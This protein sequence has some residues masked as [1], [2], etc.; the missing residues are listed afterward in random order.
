MAAFLSGHQNAVLAGLPVNDPTLSGQVNIPGCH[1]FRA[2][3]FQADPEMELPGEQP[4]LDFPIPGMS[5]LMPY[6]STRWSRM[7]DSML[8]DWEA[9]FQIAL[10]NIFRE[11]NPQVV[12]S[13]HLWL[14]TALARRILPDDIPVIGV[15]H[16]TCLRQMTLAPGV[17]ARA[18]PWIAR[19]NGIGLLTAEQGPC[20]SD[21]LI[22][23]G[24]GLPHTEVVGSGYSPEIF[25]WP[26]RGARSNTFAYAGKL[27]CSKGLHPLL[28][29]FEEL[30]NKACSENWE[31][32][33]TLVLAGGGQGA[34]ADEIRG[35]AA[36]IPGVTL[37]GRVSQ[38]QLAE[39]FG[40]SGTMVLPSFYEGLPLVIAEALA[41]GARVICSDLPGLAGWLGKELLAAGHVELVKLPE[42]CGIDTPIPE[43]LPEFQRRLLLAMERLAKETD[44]MDMASETGHF[45]A[46]QTWEALVGRILELAIQ[47]PRPSQ[48]VPSNEDS[49]LR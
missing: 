16:G 42:M 26:G 22:N 36:E 3:T 9:C 10:E 8:A 25:H 21:H 14:L 27:A 39:L 18:L 7:E 49:F 48:P 24:C 32:L 40:R 11:F 4:D 46:A 38:S 29:A 20:L 44:E 43:R 5:D 23:L 19:L 33:P 31:I 35:R 1:L 47:P 2:V 6:P 45:L 41:C 17:A 13:H 37:A 28:G 15:C 30:R 34:E 12:I